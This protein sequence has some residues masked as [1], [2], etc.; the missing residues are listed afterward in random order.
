MHA[1]H[2]DILAM[3]PPEKATDD[4]DD[5][6]SVADEGD[7]SDKEE[8]GDG[9]DSEAAV[10]VVSEAFERREVDDDVQVA[11]RPRALRMERILLMLNAVDSILI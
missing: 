11:T 8:D 2:S 1:K 6:E 5:T 7:A 9:E 4:A 3:K 10:S